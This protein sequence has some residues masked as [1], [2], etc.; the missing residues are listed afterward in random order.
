MNKGVDLSERTAG[1]WWYN[2]EEHVEVPVGAVRIAG[3][4]ILRRIG[5]D[6]DEAE[7]LFE[8]YLNKAVQ[9]DHARGLLD[10]PFS[11][12]RIT[13]NGQSL[14]PQVKVIRETASTALLDCETPPL[15]TWH[16]TL[17]HR[18]AMDVAIEKAR[19][20]G[21]GWVS[22]RSSLLVIGAQMRQAID[23]NLVGIGMTQSYPLVAPLGGFL[24][25]LGNAPIAF[26][27]PAGNHDPVIVDM[28]CT[29]TSSSGVH[30][31]A[32]HGIE[33]PA[34][35]I[36]DEFGNPTTDPASYLPTGYETH[37]R[38][39]ARGTLAVLGNSHKGYALVFVIGLLSAVLTDTNFPWE[40]GEI[41]IGAPQDGSRFGSILIAVDPAAFG[42]LD[43]IRARVDEFIEA[44][45]A[46]G[47]REGVP[48][49]LYPGEKSQRLQRERNQANVFAMPK[50]Q[51]ES[52]RALAREHGITL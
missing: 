48:E 23:A 26:G 10:F 52:F 28:S 7:Y 34:G 2:D 49:I 32:K 43:F 30:I 15:N 5:A 40:A 35:C 33:V 19:A 4:E 14:R 21:I 31:A 46:S 50:S 24:P 20:T 3:Q 37:E 1:Q 16:N 44:V 8:I 36:L 29:Q 51:F 22:L 27:V 9:G 41:S 11:V 12:R 17:F 39:K 45:K 18:A 25:M 38:Q 13:E 6:A 42:S 47:T